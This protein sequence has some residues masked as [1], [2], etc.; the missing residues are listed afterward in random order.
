MAIRS[1]VSLGINFKNSG[2]KITNVSKEV[3][4]RVWW[5]L[6]IIE[7]KLG[8]MTGRPTSISLSMC[9]SPFPLPFEE[10]ELHE[11]SAALLLND[12]ELREKRIDTAMA[13]SHLRDPPLG[14]VGSEE[15]ALA[16]R[17]W[18][19][20][21]PI[22]SGLYFLYS[23]DL[24]VVMQEL[25]N[26]V[27]SA[28]SVV[29]RWRDLKDR[30][31]VLRAKVDLWFS[32]LPPGLDFTHVEDGDYAYSEK[33]RLAFEYYSARIML[34]RPSLCRHNSSQKGSNED[35]EFTH[36]MAISTLKS[37]TQ[38]A[39]LITNNPSTGGSNTNRPWLCLLHY[40]MQTATV[41]ILELS[42]GSVHMPEEESNLLQL[43]KKC[44]RW[45]HVTS[46]H[47]V[48]SHRAWVLCDTALRRLAQPMGF[49]ICDLP[50]HP[51]Q[52]GGDVRMDFFGHSTP[53]RH[54]DPHK[55]AQIWNHDIEQRSAN[56]PYGEPNATQPIPPASHRIPQTNL[57][58][59]PTGAGHELSDEYFSHDP[60]GEEL[61]RSLF[62]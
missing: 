23:C 13:S 21:L 62:P 44:I 12:A 30:I 50:L 47:S 8:L 16:A 56:R 39:N 4:N 32:S 41:M 43:A 6:Y 34:G 36:A 52:Q 37:A 19:Q 54:P 26:H 22:N 53:S 31:D 25:L 28:K 59:S 11:P 57:L 51:H 20:S 14:K 2:R 1:A 58:I 29:V 10:S 42:F 5:S 17:S 24:T 48:A 33:M 55:N 27:Y 46:E 49:D 3:R 38:M 45:F 18:L 15:H 40:I 9:S 35:Q 60:I 7:H 61:M